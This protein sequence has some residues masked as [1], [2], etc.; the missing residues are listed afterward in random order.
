MHAPTKEDRDYA[1]S[2]A[3][4]QRIAISGENTNGV[5]LFACLVLEIVAFPCELLASFDWT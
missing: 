1:E 5:G 2:G 4:L 3:T